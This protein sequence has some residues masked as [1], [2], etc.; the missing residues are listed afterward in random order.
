M[1]IVVMTCACRVQQSVRNI[2][3]VVRH[4][5]AT[6]PRR[7][8]HRAPSRD[9]ICIPQ[10]TAHEQKLAI[11]SLCYYAQVT[12]AARHALTPMLFAFVRCACTKHVWRQPQVTPVD[13][14]TLCRMVAALFAFCTLGA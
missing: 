1:A 5:T 14:S 3:I 8:T 9:L 2:V 7:E 4:L 6:N 13:P 12:A 10:R 11:S